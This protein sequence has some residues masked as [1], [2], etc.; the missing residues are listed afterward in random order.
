MG[1]VL[2][3]SYSGYFPS[4]I[5]AARTSGIINGSLA[6]IMSIYW[7][8][9]TWQ[10]LSIVGNI[11]VLNFNQ[12]QKDLGSIS[13]TT[14]EELVCGKI[15]IRSAIVDATTEDGQ[16][17]VDFSLL[18]FPVFSKSGDNYQ[19]S[20]F[21]DFFVKGSTAASTNTEGGNIGNLTLQPINISVPYYSGAEEGGSSIAVTIGAKEWWSYGG[22]YDTQTGQPL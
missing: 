14:E 5:G 19:M 16:I 7:R 17:G 20:I 9:K 12:G 11:G 15:Y 21:S 10:I 3:A 4:C 6:N 13:A 22:T 18:L 2:H 1:Q 8:V